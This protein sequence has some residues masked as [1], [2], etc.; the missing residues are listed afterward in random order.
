MGIDIASKS[1]KRPAPEVPRIGRVVNYLDTDYMGGLEVQILKETGNTEFEGEIFQVR[2]MNPFIGQTGYKFV[3]NNNDYNSTQKSYGM[4]FVP[5]DIGTQVLVIFING[6]ASRGFWIGCIPDSYTNFMI[7]G[8]AATDYT[9]EQQTRS[10]LDINGNPILQRVPVAEVNK[11]VNNSSTSASSP[12]TSV[13]KPTHPFTTVLQNQGLVIDD[14][15][16]ITSSSARRELPSTVFGISTPG[17]IDKTANAP[18]GTIGVYNT[19]NNG[20]VNNAPV[21]RLGGTTFVMDDGNT[22]FRRKTTAKEGPPAYAS[23]DAH[24]VGGD[25]T[26][27]HNE[28]VRIRTRTGHQ[29]LLHNSEDLIYIGNASGTSW[30]ELT[31]NGK[32]DIY[33]A[34]SISVHTKADMNFYAD[35]DINMEAGRN[36]NIKSATRTQIESA[37][38]SNIIGATGNITATTGDMN[39]FGTGNFVLTAKGIFLNSTPAAIPAVPLTTFSNTYNDT[40]GTITSI[41][42]RIPNVEPWAQHE[43]LDPASMTASLTDREVSTSI[44]FTTNSKNQLVPLYYKQYTTST[45]SFR[46]VSPSGA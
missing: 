24:E 22:S 18:T 46:F 39:F 16:G 41:M 26:I 9:V 12:P 37:G 19:T 8:M 17:P 15:R 33:A 13:N 34:D 38:A 2:M 21:S 29:I 44:S 31:S 30:V 36:V 23:V 25:P 6:D 42:K 35:R 43:N 1:S 28:L 4:W 40:G 14:I 5:P 10:N 7:P 27:P 11:V 45:D 32:I 20:I 3:Q